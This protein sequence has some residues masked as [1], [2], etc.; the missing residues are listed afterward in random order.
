VGAT[1]HTGP[2]PIAPVVARMK[3]IEAALSASD[4]VARFNH[5]YLAVTLA[6]R[7]RVAT[8]V[9]EDPAFVAQL[10]VVFAG[11]YFAAIDANKAGRQP[12]SAWQPL[13]EDRGRTDVAA[14][15]FALAGMN[16][17]INFDLCLALDQVARDSGKPLSDGSPQHRDFE[18]V[19]AVLAAVEV[20]VK[21]EFDTGLVGVADATLG[22][23]D[24]VVAMWSVTR[25][26][27]AAWTHAKALAELGRV[28]MLR[29]DYLDALGGM[30]ELSSRGLLVPTL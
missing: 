24:N 19:N 1:E 12:S 21:S 18:Q 22:R 25:A 20:Q 15:Q 2:D 27:D 14:I 30:V 8:T 26:R 6:V 3:E 13:F 29:N 9:F 16:A 17:H 5:L 7:E 11:R 28:P 23:I 4:G 10:D